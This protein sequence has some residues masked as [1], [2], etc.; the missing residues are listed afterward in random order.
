MFNVEKVAYNRS[1]N[2]KSSKSMV[3]I[4]IKNSEAVEVLSMK[5]QCNVPRNP[6][7][8]QC[9]KNGARSYYLHN[10]HPREYGIQLSNVG[11]CLKIYFKIFHLFRRA[12]TYVVYWTVVS[13]I[14]YWQNLFFIRRWHS[15]RAEFVIFWL[16]IVEKSLKYSK[17]NAGVRK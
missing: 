15:L 13:T 7:I 6:Y 16:L 8:F 3:G 14:S 9:L 1:N 12:H 11:R 2:I 4:N 5:I 17:I 10:L